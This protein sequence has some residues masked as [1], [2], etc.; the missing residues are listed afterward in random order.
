MRLRF[1]GQLIHRKRS[2]TPHQSAFADS[3]PS[4]G[5]QEGGDKNADSCLGECKENIVLG[6]RKSLSIGFCS[7]RLTL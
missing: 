6:Q 3:F 2:F 5:S 7:S 4:R 1:L